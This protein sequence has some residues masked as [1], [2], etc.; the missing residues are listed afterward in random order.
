MGKSKIAPYLPEPSTLYPFKLSG[1]SLYW[2]KPI[3]EEIQSGDIRKFSEKIIDS[4]NSFPNEWHKKTLS[5]RKKL[6]KKYSEIN[7]K[8]LIKKLVNKVYTCY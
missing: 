7:E 6:I 1:I 4:V 3:F 5:H 8:K 2:K